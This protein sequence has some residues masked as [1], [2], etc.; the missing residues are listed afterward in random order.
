MKVAIITDQHWGVRNDSDVFFDYQMK[1]YDDVFFP[2][3]KERGIT[4]LINGGDFTDRRKYINY[5]TLNRMRTCYLQ[6]LGEMGIVQ[7]N[8][9]GN[10]DTFFK[11]TN[12]INSMG[13]L[14]KDIPNCNIYP[15]VSEIELD[16]L[17]IV[18]IP[19]INEANQ[20]ETINF[21][22]ET[23]TKV[24]IGHL[25]L[26]GFQMYLGSIDAHGMDTSIFD[27][28]EMVMSGHYHHKSSRGN[29]HYLGSPC[30][31]TW[32]DYN[33]PRGFHIFDTDTLELEYIQNPYRMFRKIYYNDEGL[34][35]LE[36]QKMV[37]SLKATG[38]QYT[39][40]CL[41]LLVRKKHDPH[42]FERVVDALYSMNPADLKIIEDVAFADDT[43]DIVSLAE[44]TLTSLNNHVGQMPDLSDD[45]KDKLKKLF[46]ELHSNA[47]EMED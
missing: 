20:E 12:E 11:N 17:K 47:L 25:E 27:K 3:L 29:I 13:E 45:H 4:T 39:D 41:K 19:W 33:D 43:S 24:A 18:L 10:H 26:R 38:G 1:F 36:K 15:K 31:Y 21:L 6:R 30:E 37:S 7:H 42:L 5:K 22:K 8:V 16:G 34:D 2:T 14:F 32:S 46:Q 9:V 35:P 23:K 40:R 28:F 44:D